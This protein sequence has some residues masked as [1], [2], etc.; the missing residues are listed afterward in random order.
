M[1]PSSCRD[2]SDQ[3]FAMHKNCTEEEF[4][5]KYNESICSGINN[6]FIDDDDLCNRLDEIILYHN[7]RDYW[8]P[9]Q[10]TNS[11][12][13]PSYGCVACT[14]PDY[15]HCTK[16]NQSVCI[17]PDLHCNHHPDCDDAEDEKFEEC[18]D[19]YVE[20][21]IVKE[22]ATLRCPSK[23]YPNMETISTVCDGII[24]CHNGEDE[25]EFCKNN[26]G[27]TYLAISVSSILT[28][29][30]GLK[31]YFIIFK[32]GQRHKQKT[33][34]EIM[35]NAKL[36]DDINITALRQKINDLCLHFKNY[37]NKKANAKI[38]L[39]IFALEEILCKQE[40]MVF[41]SLHNNY[42]PEVA[43]LVID[44]KFPG[45]VDKHLSII[46]KF[47][48]YINSFER[49]HT[50]RI[51]IGKSVTIVAQYSDIFK[52]IYLLLI[53]LKINGG[54]RTLYEFPLKFS[55][56]IILCVATTIVGPLIISSIQLANSNPGLIFNSKRKDKWSVRLMRAGVILTCFVNP[57]ILKVAFENVQEKIRKHSHT[58]DPSDKLVKLVNKKMKIKKQLSIFL[59][60][61]M[62]LE[63]IYQVSLQ[64]ILVLLSIS[65][66]PTTS[67]LEAFFEQTDNVAL[68]LLTC[69]SFK[70]CV[71]LQKSAVK[72]EKGFFPFTSQLVILFWS[73][74]GKS[75]NQT[76]SQYG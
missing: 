4:L 12:Q 14:N 72:T 23:I 36:S 13:D 62:G 65:K 75:S 64:L 71:L 60:V 30:L 28:I 9:H 74:L 15:F 61:D 2:K 33:E 56:M 67:G 32:N 16:N 44:S 69:W 48:D 46:H 70:T 41:R 68:I 66:T 39:K 26:D 52:D 17:H 45:F 22:F 42:L 10:C 58:S 57:M 27:N 8:D 5:Q 47:S 76:C 43:N 51:L 37:Y 59:K 29:Y 40:A 49:F 31:L 20:K 63:L 50:V 73:T 6:V 25:P 53:L 38:G 24:E 19:K 7:N 54:V 35:L 1:Y 18:K 55:S 21:F 11:C 3:V 34:A